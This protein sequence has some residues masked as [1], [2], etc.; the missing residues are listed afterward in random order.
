MKKG[1][2]VAL[3]LLSVYPYFTAAQSF[4]AVR[5]D[6]SLI[7]VAG[8]GTSS[9][10]GDLKNPGS[11]LDAKA[12]LNLGLQYYI[13]N[14]ISARAELT[15]FTLR[16]S[17]S[18]AEGPS[19][20][21][22]NLSFTSGNVELSMTGMVNL[23]P[24]GHRFY[25]RPTINI[26]PFT[27]LGITYINPRAELDGKKYALQ[28]LRTEGVKYSKIQP[29]IPFGIGPRLKSGPFFNVSFEAGWRLTFTDYLDDVSTVYP[30]PASFNSEIARRL[31]MRYETPPR[32]PITGFKRGN[33]E[34][35]DAYF[36]LNIKLEYYLPYNFLA[37]NSNRKLYKNKRKSYRK[38]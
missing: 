8:T 33:P 2:L 12:N 20:L 34:K 13:T 10:F 1:V 6:R 36:L 16:G 27:G 22:R 4:Y 23:F 32:D 11:L 15:Y 31:S 26:Y 9:Y 30:D 29:V 35:N 38:R 7:A 37:K 28:P 18:D 14:R 5:R 17:D 3:L 25:Q 24:N 19:R 21:R